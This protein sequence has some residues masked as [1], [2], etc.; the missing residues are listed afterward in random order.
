MSIGGKFM[1]LDTSSFS[2]DELTF[3]STKFNTI[4]SLLL[5]RVDSPMICTVVVIQTG[6]QYINNNGVFEDL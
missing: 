5:I 1:T 6:N 4:L 2:V 3:K